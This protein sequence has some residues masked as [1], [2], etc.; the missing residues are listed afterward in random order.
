MILEVNNKRKNNI[1]ICKF[2]KVLINIVRVKEEIIVE[3]L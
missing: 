2:F 1:F 3:I